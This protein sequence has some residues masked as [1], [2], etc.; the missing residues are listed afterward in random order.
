MNRRAGSDLRARWDLWSTPGRLVVFALAA[1]SIWCLLAEF[2]GL[3]TMR[4]VTCFVSIPSLVV[5]AALAAIARVQG[6]GRLWR[7]VAIGSGAGLVAAAAYDVF[8][9]PFVCAD[10][11]GLEG[12]LPHL[13]LFK[14][15]PRFGAMI[16]GQPVEQ[17][18]YSRSAH[19]IG[20]AYHFSNGLT[21]GVMY[22]A[23]VGDAARR[24][25]GW[26]V[27]LA[28]GLELGMLL[29]PYPG[30]FGIRLTST[31]VVVTLAAHLIFGVVLGLS[32]RRASAAWPPPL[33]LT[34]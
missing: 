5:L 11:W 12:W 14:V 1:T 8:R 22:L 24:P 10:V 7:A 26:A 29:T 30:Y 6:D 17:P 13:K 4:A 23:L 33:V 31:F 15:F 25:W 18:S 2:Y 20:W 21:F 9:L 27:L 32:A 3:G 16:L 28:I 19:L 34:A